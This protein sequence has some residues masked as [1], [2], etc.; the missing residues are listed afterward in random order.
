[1][2]PSHVGRFSPIDDGRADQALDG[3]GLV[4]VLAEHPADGHGDGMAKRG[5]DEHQQ[6][7]EQA[8]ERRAPQ[9]GNHGLPSP[10]IAR[11]A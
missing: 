9:D 4:L 1:M 5:G 10:V 6:E 3:G 8:D 11:S 2:K 7:R